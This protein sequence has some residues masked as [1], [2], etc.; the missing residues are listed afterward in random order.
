MVRRVTVAATGL[1]LVGGVLASTPA[2]AATAARI[3]DVQGAAHVS[4]LRGQVVS[5]PGIVTARASNGFY[6]QDP[7]PDRDPRT[8]EAI[9][10]FTGSAPSVAVGDAV[11]VEGTVTEFRPGGADGTAN[12]TAT[13]LTTPT[14][15]V[16]SSGNA[17]PATTVLGAGGR[18]PPTSVVENDANGDVEAGGAFDPASDGL[19]FY[20]SLEAM[21]VQVNSA[22]A[23]GPTNSFNELPVLGDRGR[24]AG[25]RSVRGGVV[26]RPGDANPERIILDDGLGFAPPKVDVGATATG[27][28]VGVVSYSFGNVKVILTAATAF[29]G[30]PAPETTRA[31]AGNELSVATFNVENL[32]PSDPPAKFARLA[33]IIVRN[34]RAPDV[35]ALEEVQDNNGA[36]NDG[37]VA[38]DRTYATLIAAITAAGGPVYAYRQIDPVNNADGGE[39]GGNIRVGFLYAADRGVSFASAPAGDATTPVAV[40]TR[41]GKP[42]LS[43]NP[44]RIAPA[45]AA[46]ADSRKPLVGEFTYRGRSVFV[47][48]NHF[49]SK[50][51]DQPLFGRFQPP[52]QPSAAKRVQQATLV[53]AFVRQLLAVDR[54]A[55]V[56]V[57]GDL[58]DFE[59]SETVKTVAGTQLIDLPATLPVPERYTYVFDGNSQVLDHILISRSVRSYS[60]DIVHVNAEYTDQASDHDPQLVRLRLP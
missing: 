3:H 39:P 14:V 9:L 16:T 11:T 17:L 4:P 52:A 5:V 38:A 36:T 32:D 22:V 56:A 6:L 10:V 31:D 50:S 37:T 30:T 1:L 20:E 45:E 23:A 51:G 44:G 21:R 48:A 33:S 49:V 46:W 15:T 47:V 43:V 35:V 18:R 13:Q 12:L 60:Y 54:Q 2:Q 8:S 42:H 34:L 25:P 59:F 24:S 26:L 28:A 55:L 40:T 27:P 41:G 53:N 7:Q 29:S 57:V 58:N 19:D